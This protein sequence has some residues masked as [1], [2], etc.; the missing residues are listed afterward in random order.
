MK[1]SVT[2]ADH[3]VVDSVGGVV[4]KSL[5]TSLDNS[6]FPTGRTKSESSSPVRASCFRTSAIFYGSFLEAFGL[7]ESCDSKEKFLRK[8]SVF[9][10]CMGDRSIE[11]L[12][13]TK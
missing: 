10:I 9:G 13:D 3:T 1:L 11:S 5:Y 6:K 12:Y 7:C 8:G 2:V 4:D